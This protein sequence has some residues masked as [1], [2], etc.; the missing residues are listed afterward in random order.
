MNSIGKNGQPSMEEIL[1][2]IRRIVA[3]DSHGPGT[4]APLIDLN[5]KLPERNTSTLS[6][7]SADFELPSM[8]RPD[9]ASEVSVSGAKVL[10]QKAKQASIG[11]LTDAIRNVSQKPIDAGTKARQEPVRPSQQRNGHSNGSSQQGADFGVRAKPQQELSSLNAA[12]LQ[13]PSNGT[14]A[15]YPAN[16]ANGSAPSNL[17]SDLSTVGQQREQHPQAAGTPHAD[18]V[19]AMNGHEATSAPMTTSE[20]VAPKM[21]GA[22]QDKP[23]VMA[24]F[25]DTKMNRMSAPAKAPSTT[26]QP[27]TQAVDLA[28]SGS[29]IGSIVPGALDLPGRGPGQSQ[30]TSG[31]PADPTS[32]PQ[33]DQRLN[34]HNAA[35]VSSDPPPLPSGQASDSPQ[36][37]EDATADL[38]RPMLRQWLTE[39]MP[40]MVEKA[41]HIEVAETVKTGKPSS[42]GSS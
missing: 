30:G 42:D 22:E 37:I 20:P 41:L 29:V 39:N 8:F 15:P 35:D 24:P 3:D 36:K 25:R 34:A 10:G 23:R 26:P 33:A 38:L 27:S 12:S 40:R 16:G 14:A 9:N 1:A 5:R 6:D 31:A 4:P 32:A 19:A 2:S 7:D 13:Q 17:Q 18:Q 28:T 11:R 21:A